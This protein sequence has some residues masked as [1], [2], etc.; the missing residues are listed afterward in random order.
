MTASNF[1]HLLDTQLVSERDD[2]LREQIVKHEWAQFQQDTNE[3][4]PANC[5]GN[6]PTFHQMRFSQFATWPHKLLASYSND[7]DQ[8]D[9]E[10]RNLLT[11]KYAR[12]MESTAP[13]EYQK[14]IAPF[15]PKLGIKRQSQQERIINQQVRW[16][17]NFRDRYPTVGQTMRVLRTADDTP[18]D[19]S[20]ETYLRGELS[21]Y[22]SQTFQLYD[23][24]IVQLASLDIN[25]TEATV[26]ETV[27]LAGYENLDQAEAAQGI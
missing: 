3:G 27:R 13:D 6:W 7:L 21:I 19:T 18:E 22:S 25:L 12:M 24:F 5:Q 10:G 17:Q 2:D 20:F 26:L 9:T 16:A 8:A 4:G 23:A 11:E 14:H 1:H 15:I